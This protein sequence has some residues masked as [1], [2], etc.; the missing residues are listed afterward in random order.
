M[1]VD[2]KAQVVVGG[3]TRHGGNGNNSGCDDRCDSFI[4]VVNVSS[5][6]VVER[7]DKNLGMTEATEKIIKESIGYFD[8][9]N[10]KDYSGYSGFVESDFGWG[11][12]P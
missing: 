2:G 3:L 4:A 5:S 11:V 9:K 12:A 6:Y 10:G 8:R 7:L 1:L